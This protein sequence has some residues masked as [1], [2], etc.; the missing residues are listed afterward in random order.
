MSINDNELRQ[1]LIFILSVS[2]GKFDMDS[3]ILKPHLELEIDT[4]TC[5]SLES[6]PAVTLD[7]AVTSRTLCNAYNFLNQHDF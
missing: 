2:S 6:L 7:Y 1:Q 4:I 5:K 3:N